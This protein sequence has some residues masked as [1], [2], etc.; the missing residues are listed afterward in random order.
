MDVANGGLTDTGG[1]IL[2][3]PGYLV[4]AVIAYSALLATG[5]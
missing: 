1:F 3:V 4:V 5:I 2:T